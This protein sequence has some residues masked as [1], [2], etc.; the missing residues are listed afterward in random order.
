MFR[1]ESYLKVHGI[2]G[3]AMVAAMEEVLSYHRYNNNVEMVRDL[4]VAM[5]NGIGLYDDYVESWYQAYGEHWAIL[6]SRAGDPDDTDII[7]TVYK[8]MSGYARVFWRAD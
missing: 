5:L 6:I 4:V 2:D 1:L 8:S 3:K 7:C